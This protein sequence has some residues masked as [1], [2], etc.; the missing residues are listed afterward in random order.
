M[1]SAKQLILASGSPRRQEL[2]SR[3]G[4]DFDVIPAEVAEWGADRFAFRK[5]CAANATLKAREV[6]AK[7]PDAVVLGADTLVG[8]QGSVLGKPRDIVE[9]V[10]M[11]ERLSGRVHEVCTGVCVRDG[12]EEHA[13]FEVTWVQFQKFGEEVIKEYTQRVDVMDKAGA[14]A[15]Q[16]HGEMLVEKV[17]GSYENVVGLPVARVA[18]ELER[19]AIWPRR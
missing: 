9:A 1:T 5:L 8:L 17:E 4:Y 15:I 16:E 7:H 14:Y 6:Q 19:F 2:L 11:L 13:F 12:E 3:A 18:A 10:C